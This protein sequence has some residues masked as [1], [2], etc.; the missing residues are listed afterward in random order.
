VQ[1]RS[2]TYTNLPAA[3][4]LDEAIHNFRLVVDNQERL[5]LP[6]KRISVAAND[7]SDQRATSKKNSICADRR[8]RVR[9]VKL[10]GAPAVRRV[11]RVVSRFCP[12]RPVSTI[13][14]PPPS[15]A[16]TMARP[17]PLRH[18]PTPAD[19]SDNRHYVT[20]MLDHGDGSKP[21]C[22]HRDRWSPAQPISHSVFERIKLPTLEHAA[23]AR[24][25]V[26]R[27]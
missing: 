6:R 26:H 7:S 4:D 15:S 23:Q 14:A 16:S 25:N 22:G 1:L 12:L 2:K 27:R 8:L 17:A 13:S 21:R 11:R 5:W 18:Q 3:R 24:S 10:L 20:S 9:N 19:R